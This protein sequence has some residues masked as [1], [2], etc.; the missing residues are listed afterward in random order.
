PPSGSKVETASKVDKGKANR[1]PRAGESEKATL[2]GEGYE[3]IAENVFGDGRTIR[4]LRVP[5]S[6]TANDEADETIEVRCVLP[7]GRIITIRLPDGKSPSNAESVIHVE[8]E[9]RSAASQEQTAKEA[10]A[11]GRFQVSPL[12]DSAILVDTETGKTWLLYYP[13]KNLHPRANEA[14]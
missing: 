1:P 5:Q 11:I 7:S 12:G 10:A 14:R 2:A 6:S 9:Y 13:N 3:Q 4:I 8:K